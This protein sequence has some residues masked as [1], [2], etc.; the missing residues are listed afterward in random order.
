MIN[1]RIVVLQVIGGLSIGG[2]ES[3]IMDILR[4]LDRD[5]FT[6]DFLL[7]EAPGQYEEEARSLGSNIYRTVKY[8]VYNKG[9]YLS[10]L[11]AFFAAHPEIDIVQGHSTNTA[12][13]YL[14]LAKAAGIPVTIAH[15][16][17]AG[18]EPGIAGWLKRRTRRGLFDK[19]DICFACSR[20]AAAAVFGKEHV[21]EVRIIPNAIKA[22]RFVPDEE[23][24]QS[25]IRLRKELGLGDSYV[26]GHVGRFHYAKNHEFLLKVFS[27]IIKEKQNAK[28][29]IVGDGSERPGIEALIR[30]MKLTDKVILAGMQ[31]DTAKYYHAMDVLVFPSFYEG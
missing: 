11:K 24:L 8:K 5:R 28:L 25:G 15:A 31:K 10:E 7:N 18:V 2:A 14:P 20:E 26:V 4:E 21:K 3:R 22:D 12:A 17:S 1:G 29:L 19:S 13:L 9:R 27:A 16:R 6:Y 23:H 30:E